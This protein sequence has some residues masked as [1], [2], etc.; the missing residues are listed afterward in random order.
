M[1]VKDELREWIRG[2]FNIGDDPDY[3]DDAD[4]FDLGFV[5]SF[6][7]V[8]IIDH[9]ETTHGVEITQRDIVVHGMKTLDEIA[10]VVEGKLNT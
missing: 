1:S 10:G 3:T 6:G 8:E 4:I 9:I 5:D 7:A 2:H